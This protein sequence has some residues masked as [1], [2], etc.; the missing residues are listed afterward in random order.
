MKHCM[1]VIIRKEIYRECN[2]HIKHAYPRRLLLFML[3][4]NQRIIEIQ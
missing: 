1:T 3:G 4:N 2:K